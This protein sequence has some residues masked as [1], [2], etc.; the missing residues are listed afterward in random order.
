MYKSAECWNYLVKYSLQ[1]MD[2]IYSSSDTCTR[3][4]YI[5]GQHLTTNCMGSCQLTFIHHWLSTHARQLNILS[6]WMTVLKHILVLFI[7]QDL[8]GSL[9]FGQVKILPIASPWVG[10]LY[11]LVYNIINKRCLRHLIVIR[12]VC[13]VFICCYDFVSVSI[14]F[15]C[16]FNCSDCDFSCSDSVVFLFLH[17]IYYIF[18]QPLVKW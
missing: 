13:H 11:I 16:D 9:L 1:W 17:F 14:I 18:R 15:Q 3:K 7:P 8:V 4:Q 10:F 6:N 2:G 5:K 12:L